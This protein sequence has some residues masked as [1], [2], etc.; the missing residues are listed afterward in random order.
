MYPMGSNGASQAILDATSLTHNL[1]RHTDPTEALKAYEDDRL[2]AT[3]KVVRRNRI[4]G[5]IA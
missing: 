2:A 3:S 4:D 1:V 5:R